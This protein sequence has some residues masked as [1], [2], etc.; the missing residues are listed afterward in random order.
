MS[1]EGLADGCRHCP[2]EVRQ[3]LQDTKKPLP[4]GLKGENLSSILEKPAARH[5]NGAQ[6]AR[7]AQQF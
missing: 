7:R 2:G 3:E 1:K 4:V 5:S 6:A